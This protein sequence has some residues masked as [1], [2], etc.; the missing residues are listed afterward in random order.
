MCY[1]RV[2]LKERLMWPDSTFHFSLSFFHS[3]VLSDESLCCSLFSYQSGEEDWESANHMLSLRHCLRIL[4]SLKQESIATISMK[5]NKTFHF[6]RSSSF[7]HS[8]LIGLSSIHVH[9]M[10]RWIHTLSTVVLSKKTHNHEVAGLYLPWTT[11][12]C[13][14]LARSLENEELGTVHYVIRRESGKDGDGV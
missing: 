13:W 3:F 6:V 9:L 12:L 11:V 2:R 8:V 7:S 5:K 1:E 10:S 14:L 4:A